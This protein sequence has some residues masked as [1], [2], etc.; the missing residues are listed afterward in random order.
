[1]WR[2]FWTPRGNDL[3]YGFC[4][5]TV[6]DVLGSCFSKSVCRGVTIAKLVLRQIR[7]L[8]NLVADIPA[9]ATTGKR[10]ATEDVAS[11]V[12]FHDLNVLWPHDALL[13][14]EFKR[15]VV[16]QLLK[17]EKTPAEVSRVPVCALREARQR[18]RDL[19]RLLGKKQ[20]EIETHRPGR[21]RLGLRRD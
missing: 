11:E 18:I 20:M 21:R 7:E 10:N 6:A 8:E 14:V 12:A 13:T 4:V 5:A 1:V 17:G 3:G 16:Q 19:E 2:P 15:G 9:S